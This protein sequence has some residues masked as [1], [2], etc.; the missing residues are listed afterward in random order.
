MTQEEKDALTEKELELQKRA[1]VLED[2]Q[3]QHDKA[4]KDDWRNSAIERYSKGDS[5]KAKKIVEA[6]K[7]LSGDEHDRSSIEAK[8]AKAAK[9]SREDK[10][11]DHVGSAFGNFNGAP[12]EP[13][14]E[15]G[16]GETEEGAAL[17][18]K[19]GFRF[20]KKK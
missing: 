10:E 13:P 12:P 17:A 7:D 4:I 11:F 18:N 8:V 2:R 3:T 15:K 6:L 5:D 1:E 9:L 16:F 14:A 20:A 19:L